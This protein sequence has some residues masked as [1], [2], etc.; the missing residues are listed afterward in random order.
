MRAIVIYATCE[1]QTDR[2]AKRIAVTVRQQ[3]IPTDTFDVS[4]NDVCE[5]AVES[6]EAVVFG[7]SLHYGDHDPRVAWCLRNYRK[8][9][10]HV[11][12]SFFSFR[13]GI[14]SEHAKD[15]AKVERL[16]DEFLRRNEFEPNQKACFAGALRYSRYG[17]VKKQVMHRIAQKSGSETETDR[18]YEYTDWQAVDEF[19]RK[20][21]TLV[22]SRYLAKSIGAI[23]S[24]RPFETR[25]P[26]M[27]RN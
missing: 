18:D 27:S 10:K 1:G 20:F 16:A 26:I 6:Y 19:A 5:L 4:K 22:E 13:L 14:L 8:W 11:P 24:N 2:I 21:A 23:R 9:L 17:W 7:S 3:G 12:T 15:R 25:S